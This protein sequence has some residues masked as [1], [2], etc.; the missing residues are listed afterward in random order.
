MKSQKKIPQPKRDTTRKI[1]LWLPSIILFAIGFLVYSNTISNGFV[2]DDVIVITGNRYTQ[3]GV[4][5]IMDIFTHDAFVGAYGEALNLTGGRYRPFSI[6]M[7]AIEK[8]LWGHNPAVHHFFN[9]LFF[10]LTCVLIFHF[11][12][13]LLPQQNLF[14]PF[15][16]SLLFAVHPI[17][18]EVVANIKSRD[19]ILVLFFLLISFLLLFRKEKWAIAGSGIIYFFA[20]LSKEN[21]VTFVAW[22]PLA[23][24]LFFNKPVK[25]IA[26]LAIPFFAITLLYI[27]MRAEFAGIVGD[28]IT[29]DIMDDHFMYATFIE[30]LATIS[31]VML[32]YVQLLFFPHPL[33]YDYSFNQIPVTDFSSWQ[34]IT[35]LSLHLGLVLY[36][37]VFFRKDKIISFSILFY[38]AAMSL[39]SNLIFN[40]GTPLAERFIYLGSLGFCFASAALLSRIFKIDLAGKIKLK[41]ALIASVG[42]VCLLFSVK[43]FTRNKVW[44]DNYDLYKTDVETVPNSARARLY[45]GIECIK[46]YD[47]TKNPADIREA[48][49]QVKKSVEINPAFTFAYHNLGV[50]YQR[51]EMHD[52]AIECYKKLRSLDTTHY[53]ALYGLGLSYGKGKQQ[54]DKAIGFLEK[55]VYVHK[56]NKPEYFDNLALCYAMKGETA[57]AKD[58]FLKGLSISPGDVN[59]NHNLGSLYGM[60]GMK[61]SA[62][63]YMSRAQ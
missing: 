40:V 34:A 5:G 36:A 18:T 4:A 7:F 59:L 32:K 31:V 2:L 38:L 49:D 11:V 61:D 48:I 24:F 43:T 8:E 58:I 23:L 6:A 30:K 37:I 62:D 55:L 26:I 44:K 27:W 20:L 57:K 51:I 29:T 35:G 17:H 33:S 54:Y 16:A 46:V 13:K 21:A 39:V 10:A 50:A 25:R 9:V 1:N 22:M 14:I 12:R 19:E 63:Y 15:T 28:R 47:K 53:E 41:P 52:E 45:Y 60:A 56:G 42:V 3:Q